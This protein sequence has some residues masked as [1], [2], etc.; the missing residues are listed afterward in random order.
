MELVKPT[1]LA[2][3]RNGPI[4]LID[5]KE[6][7][8]LYSEFI[9]FF[10]NSVKILNDIIKETPNDPNNPG[11]QNFAN[12]IQR[13]IGISLQI[14]SGNLT[15][16]PELIL[17]NVSPIGGNQ[18]GGAEILVCNWIA[19]LLVLFFLLT[20]CFP[21]LFEPLINPD[22]L[23]I[24]MRDTFGIFLYRT[25]K[26]TWHVL[27]EPV[28]EIT[29]KRSVNFGEL[30]GITSVVKGAIMWNKNEN[31]K[32]AFYKKFSSFII[33]YLNLFCRFFGFV[34]SARVQQLERQQTL[35]SFYN[36]YFVIDTANVNLGN[37]VNPYNMSQLISFLKN[38]TGPN[39]SQLTPL[40]EEN[41][42]NALN[43]LRNN[44]PTINNIS[45]EILS[46]NIENITPE[47]FQS[48]IFW[49]QNPFEEVNTITHDTFRTI[50]DDGSHGPEQTAYFTT[51]SVK[52]RKLFAPPTIQTA[53]P[54]TNITAS[55]VSLLNEGGRRR[56]RRRMQ[57]SKRGAKHGG[58]SR[59][60]T[61]KRRMSKRKYRR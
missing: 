53:L 51:T 46:E 25:Y 37:S 43:T 13:F 28:F 6:Q 31:I 52:P 44:I 40:D 48:L 58:K 2:S 47:E 19:V 20:F 41:I 22:S 56:S 26:I 11:L 55:Q 45:E 21:S 32:G 15:K 3:K 35:Q 23:I 5:E 24:K 18:F 30:M 36:N 59:M 7:T 16:T 17:G 42:H 34:D 9:D 61:K 12:N 27:R 39:G 38:G 10:N 57:K 1:T 50:N 14:Q 29:K 49:I 54:V 4:I 33:L 8:K 60:R